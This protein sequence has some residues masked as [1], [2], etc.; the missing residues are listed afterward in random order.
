MR[1]RDGDAF[2]NNNALPREEPFGFHVVWTSAYNLQSMHLQT[3]DYIKKR[4]GAICISAAPFDHF[5]G[6]P[7]WLVSRATSDN[8]SHSHQ[9]ACVQYMKRSL[10]A[11]AG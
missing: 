9:G 1:Q 4:N 3:V 2:H 11:G 5:G 6:L 8:M 10:D 7:R